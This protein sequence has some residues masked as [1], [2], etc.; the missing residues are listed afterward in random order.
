[1]E[2]L[3]NNIF[4]CPV[5]TV[6][7]DSNLNTTEIKEI[8]DI[9][10]EGMEGKNEVNNSTSTNSFI[11]DTRLH[12][13]KEFCEKHIKIYINTIINPKEEVNF[14]IT[15]SWL[16]ITKPGENHQ[17]HSHKNSIISGVFYVA[18]VE[19]DKINFYEPNKVKQ[20]IKFEPKEF[21]LWNSDSWSFPVTNN[22]LI[23]FPSWLEHGVEP[24]E[25]AT[26]DRISISFDTFVRFD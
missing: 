5:Y 3:I 22:E 9:I 18:T 2:P 7:R 11:F 21:N 8:E 25:K 20:V 14:Y 1:M 13:L 23:L 10:E 4:P 15:Q 12:N 17:V 6:K 24:N 16:T 26:T 19:V